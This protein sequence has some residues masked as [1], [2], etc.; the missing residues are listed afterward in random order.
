[1]VSETMLFRHLQRQLGSDIFKSL[2]IE[3][4]RDI[5]VDES[6][7]TFSLYYPHM[8]QNISITKKDAIPSIHPQTNKEAIYKYK[9]PIV[10]PDS[11]YIGIE[12]FYHPANHL[13]GNLTGLNPVMTDMMY[14]KIASYLPTAV[15]RFT[16]TF[17]A[18]D[19]LVIDPIQTQHQDF[20]VTMQRVK[21]LHEIPMYYIELFK[22]LF[23]ADVKIAIY[24]E[25]RNA[26]DTTVFGGIEVNTYISEFSDAVS[27]R[28]GIIEKMQADYYK[29]PARIRAI[30]QLQ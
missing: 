27:T 24:N 15:I 20:S 3:Y 17:E 16:L 13:Q 7:L 11:P 26:R 5:L 25:L 8:I 29:D 4:Y 6:L 23:V 19:I 1:M 12:M 18:P 28:E 22:N 9:I 21:K 10:D 30:T 14:G 2:T